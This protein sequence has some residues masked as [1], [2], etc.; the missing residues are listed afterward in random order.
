RSGPVT[1]SAGAEVRAYDRGEHTFA[2]G[3]DPNS[4]ADETGAV[5]Q[6][7]EAALIA[8]DGTEAPRINGHLAYWFGWYAFYPET[9][10][11]AP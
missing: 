2:P 11:Y 9:L 3:P 10:V 8:P 7:T 1:Y 6:I 4:V 5:W